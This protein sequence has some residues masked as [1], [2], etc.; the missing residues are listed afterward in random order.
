MPYKQGWETLVNKYKEIEREKVEYEP[1]KDILVRLEENEGEFLKGYRDLCKM[2]EKD[3]ELEKSLEKDTEEN[4]EK[5]E[6]V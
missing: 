6:M 1:V 2:L 3:E 4:L 5:E